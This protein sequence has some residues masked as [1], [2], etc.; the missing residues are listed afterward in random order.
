MKPMAPI[1][2]F[3]PLSITAFVHDV[4]AAA[5]AWLIAYWL[6]L[7]LAIP[8]EF[9]PGMTRAMLICLPLQAYAYL[10]FGLYRGVWRYA[11]V[12][13]SRMLKPKFPWRAATA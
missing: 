6:R 10:A 8:P 1:L 7:N 4:A 3:N 2:G 12:A 13:L 9:V 11:S 5:V